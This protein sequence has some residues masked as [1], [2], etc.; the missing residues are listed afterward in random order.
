MGSWGRSEATSGSDDDFMVLVD[1]PEREYAQPSIAEVQTVLTCPPGDQGIFGVPVFCDSLVD[2]IGLDEDDNNNLSRRML[3]LLES[4][5]ATAD[6]VYLAAK[7][8]VLCRYLDESIKDFRPPRFLLNDTVRYWRTM[9]VDFAGKERKSGEKWGLRNAKL[10][11]SRKV[12]FAGGLL[13]ILECQKL[14]ADDMF[15]FLATQFSVP[16]TDRIAEVFLTTARPTPGP[17]H[18]ARTTSSSACWMTSCSARP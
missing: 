7:E 13:P 14:A 6:D 1:G 16:P 18:S 17:A 5:P 2:N 12:L 10:R 3:F 4:V 15:A 8:R 9:C 11:T